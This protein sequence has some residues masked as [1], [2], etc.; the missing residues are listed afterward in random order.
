MK[1]KLKYILASASLIAVIIA[2][3]ILNGLYRK[4][5]SLITCKEI[6]VR[7]TDSL[8]F[9]TE[10]DIK[11]YLNRNYTGLIGE[12][13]DSIRLGQIENLLEA[14]SSINECEA[15][16]DRDGVLH[17]DVSQRKPVLRFMNGQKGFYIDENAY[18]FPLHP[19]Y[20]ADVP[21]IEGNIPVNV[22]DRFKGE[23]PKEDERAWLKSVLDLQR[24]IN[25]SPKYR[26]KVKSIYVNSNSD[27]LLRLLGEN[28][29]FNIGGPERAAEKFEKIGLYTDRIKPASEEMKYRTVNVKYEN[30]IICRKG[31]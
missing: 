10:N 18:I 14:K 13:L 21:V 23:A 29:T 17:L 2:S 31:M 11:N 1:G 3:V 6:S 5:L 27:I 4:D 12:R 8:L 22:S 26:E 9:V 20:T 24:F 15:W 19:S 28:E 7:L 16:V 25:S 30:Q